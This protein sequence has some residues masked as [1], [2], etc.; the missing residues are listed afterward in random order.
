MT[1]SNIG[2]FFQRD[3]TWFEPAKAWIDYLTR[4]QALLQ[5]GRPVADIVYFTGEE[6]PNRALL[7]ERYAPSLPAGYKADSINRDALLRLATVR[8]GRIELPGG[9]N[10]AVLVLPPAQREFSTEFLTKVDEL[11][12][13]GA[14]IYRPDQKVTLPEL[15]AQQKLP[16]DFVPTELSGQPTNDVEWTHRTLEDGDIYF[17]SRFAPKAVARICLMR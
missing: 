11:E 14:V 13:A 9:A 10:Y 8:N 5:Q 2:L 16:P 3:Q 7:P 4:C 12:K 15:L 6:L 17:V 1:L